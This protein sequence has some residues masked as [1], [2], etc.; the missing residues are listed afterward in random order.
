M[1]ESLSEDRVLARV[2]ALVAIVA[3]LLAATG[4]FSVIS[5]LVTERTRDF[6]IRTALG[7]TPA[8]ILRLVLRGVAA[9][10]VLGIAAGP[11]CTGP[12]RDGSRRASSVLAG[13]TR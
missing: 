7:A 9:R 12:P 6:G 3:A 13:S 5:Q 10:S 2:S 11:R 1:A 8:D 4:V